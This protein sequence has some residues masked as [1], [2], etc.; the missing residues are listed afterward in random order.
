MV[1]QLTLN[2]YEERDRERTAL[3]MI[4][5]SEIAIRMEMTIKLSSHSELSQPQLVPGSFKVLLYFNKYSSFL[6]RMFMLRHK[7]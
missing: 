5:K 7:W 6:A 4:R 2:E 1:L 3:S